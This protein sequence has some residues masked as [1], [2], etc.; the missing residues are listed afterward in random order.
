MGSAAVTAVWRVESTRLVA[1]LTRITG[2][3][4]LAEDVVQDALVAALDQWPRDGVPDNP[5]AWLMTTAKRRAIDHFRRSESLRRRTA[6]LGHGLEE[7]EVPDLDAAVDFIED[8]VI[9]LIF[10]CCHPSLTADSRAALTLRLV[11]GLSTAEIARGFLV[12]EATM[13]QR[14]TR[15]KRTL[16]SSRARLEL[17]TGADR[18]R[19]LDDVMA[20]I[21]LIF[22]EGYAATAGAEWTR[23]DLCHEA[24]RLARVLAGLVPD[25]PEVHSLQA[26]LELQGSRLHARVDGEGQ[27]VLLA[28]QDRRRWDLLLV[29]RGQAALARAERLAEKGRPVGRYYLQAAIAAEH[30]RALRGDDT[31]WATIAQ[32]YD[33]LAEAAPGPV[34]EVNR[35]VAHGRAFGPEAGLAVLDAIP[36]DELEGSHLPAAVR[37]DLLVRLGRRSEAAA[38]FRTAAAL[39]RNQGERILLSRRATDADDMTTPRWQVSLD[40]AGV[41]DRD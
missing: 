30:A 14:I 3:V 4:G 40:S 22:N 24:I 10:L 7:V 25:E 12:A 16:A 33:V 18:D 32:L 8:D 15:A 34:V 1:A 27:P 41:S 39:T 35:A 36:A 17:P 13:G 21:Y 28:D 5:A 9:R 6:E 31:D 2:D 23:P 26:L 38:A 11:V 19:R 37:G 29:R 20:V